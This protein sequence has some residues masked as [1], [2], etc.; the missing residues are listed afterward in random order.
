MIDINTAGRDLQDEILSV[1]RASQETVVDALQAWASTAQSIT[2]SFAKVNLPYAD[3]LPKPEALVS[4][5][6]DFTEQLLSVQRKFA[7]DVLQATAP[8]VG[9]AKAA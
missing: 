7:N 2:P 8:L 9:Q 6:Y 4:Q 5:T 1:I 3:W